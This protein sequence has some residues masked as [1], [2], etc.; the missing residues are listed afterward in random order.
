MGKRD[1][2]GEQPQRPLVDLFGVGLFCDPKRTFLT[3]F[4]VVASQIDEGLDV[5][6]RVATWPEDSSYRTAAFRRLVLKSV[7]NCPARIAA[8]KLA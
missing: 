4:D 6:P 1:S 7:F 5:A 3:R 2:L 8:T